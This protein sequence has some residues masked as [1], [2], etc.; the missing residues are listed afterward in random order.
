M[1]TCSAGG[2]LCVNRAAVLIGPHC[3]IPSGVNMAPALYVDL[4]SR[5]MYRMTNGFSNIRR[6]GLEKS[7]AYVPLPRVSASFPEAF[8]FN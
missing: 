4:C 2:P 3:I 1:D 6:I 8:G 5:D 7:K